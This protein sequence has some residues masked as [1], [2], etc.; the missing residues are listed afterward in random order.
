MYGIDTARIDDYAE[1]KPDNRKTVEK[2]RKV[3]IWEH[4]VAQLEVGFADVGF[5]LAC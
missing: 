4:K 3:Y 2:D 1:L 5:C